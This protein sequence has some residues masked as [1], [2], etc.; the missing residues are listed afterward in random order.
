[1][2]LPRLPF[3]YPHLFKNYR[4]VES[5]PSFQSVS[6]IQKRPRR[7][8]CSTSRRFQDFPQ[9]YGPA[10]Q[11]IQESPS[12]KATEKSPASSKVDAKSAPPKTPESKDETGGQVPKKKKDA[13]TEPEPLTKESEKKLD[14]PAINAMESYVKQSPEPPN[15]EPTSK[16][17][18]T[19]L[20]M[21]APTAPKPAEHK[22][23]HLQATPYVHHF[24]TYTLV[25]DLGQGGFTQDQSI[26]IMKSVRSLLAANLELANDGLVSKSDVENVCS[27]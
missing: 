27:P 9:R 7:S 4:I 16:P 8:F 11:P 23:P 15:L 17:L 22:P 1:M 6:R 24:D 20:H 12:E 14:T 21:E 19:V 18:E 5:S 2:S 3:L 26:T 25:K 13:G 10:T